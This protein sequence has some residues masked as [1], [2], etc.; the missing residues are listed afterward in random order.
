[1]SPNELEIRLGHHF[2]QPDLLIQALTHRSFGVPHNERLEFLGDSVLNCAVAS[3]IYRLYPGMPEG[4]LS[5]MRANLVN[6]ASLADI[7]VLLGLGN[8]LRMGEGEHKTGGA[9]RPS[10]LADALE[11]LLGAIFL[12]AGFERAAATIQL[13]FAQRL[14]S[15][16]E[17]KPAKDAK[18]ALQEW[19]QARRLPLPLY[20]VLKIEG[21]AHR[22]EFHVRCDVPSEDVTAVGTGLSRRTAE[23]DAA[24]QAFESITRQPDGETP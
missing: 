4:Q 18:T 14:E 16:N 21:E 20:T 11:A 6:Q 24:L 15:A 22:Q 1:M 23:Q 2:V 10:I 12:D 8:L 9:N 5:R 17:G 13:L 7:A 3:L 19:L